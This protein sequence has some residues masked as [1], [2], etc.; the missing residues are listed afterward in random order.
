VQ[1][2]NEPKANVKIFNYQHLVQAIPSLPATATSYSPTTCPP[3]GHVHEMPA[4]PSQS[5]SAMARQVGS[6]TRVLDPAMSSCDVADEKHTHSP[7]WPTRALESQICYRCFGTR[8]Y[9]LAVDISRPKAAIPPSL[10]N[11]PRRSKTHLLLDHRVGLEIL[12]VESLGGIGSRSSSHLLE[13]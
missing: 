3:A 8:C 11:H 7:H 5:P 10:A 6:P 12:N 9:S 1:P 4:T 13:T 2:R